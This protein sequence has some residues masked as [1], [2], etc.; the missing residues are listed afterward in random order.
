MIFERSK[1]S[2]FHRS[3]H[4][5]QAAFLAGCL[6]L[7]DDAL[8]DHVVDDRERSRVKLLRFFLVSICDG[9]KHAFD[10]SARL[11][12]HCHVVAPTLLVL[13]SA[14]R[15]GAGVSQ[16]EILCL[17]P[18][19]SAAHARKPVI[20]FFAAALVNPFAGFRRTGSSGVAMP[21]CINVIMR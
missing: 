10:V 6:V 4:L 11:G 21:G 15:G 8:V 20:V 5:V 1:G 13:A 3:K 2:G 14:L 12:A 19:A 16:V 9:R 7:V 18:R 17:R